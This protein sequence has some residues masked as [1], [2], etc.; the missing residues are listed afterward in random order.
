MFARRFDPKEPLPGAAEKL[1]RLLEGIRTGAPHYEEMNPVFARLVERNL[2][3]MRTISADLGAVQAIDF[4][5]PLTE[6]WDIYEVHRE[7]GMGRWKI[8]LDSDGR[9]FG[10]IPIGALHLP[11][12]PY[13]CH[14][15]EMR[16]G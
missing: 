1:R 13:V 7:Q 12:D 4:V 3:R 10:A 6:G 15:D 11:C 9:I 14:E 2:A 16:L 5:A 8:A